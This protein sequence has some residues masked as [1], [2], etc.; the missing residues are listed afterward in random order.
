MRKMAESVQQ[1]AT[2]FIIL[3]YWIGYKWCLCRAVNSYIIVM[4]FEW[5][6][7]DFRFIEHLQIVTTCN[8]NTNTNSH[9]LQFTTAHTKSS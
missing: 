2:V 3:T 8:H 4:C 1:D 6:Q 5:L 7:M 9:S